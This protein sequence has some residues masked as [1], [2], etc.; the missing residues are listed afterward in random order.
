MLAC[1][2]DVASDVIGLLCA[3]GSALVFV[4]SNIFFKK[5]VP[6]NSSG[7]LASSSHKLDKL[8]LL[9]YSSGMAFLLMVPLWLYYDL[10]L[11]LV[12]YTNPDHIFHPKQGHTAPHSVTYYF[13]LNGA[14]H[15]AQNIIAFIILSSTSPV[16]YSIASLVKRVV[17]ICIAILWFNQ[18]VHPLQAIGIALTFTGLY[19]YNNAK[20][21]VEKGEKKM[22]RVQVAQDMILPTIK[23]ESREISGT[24]T[25]PNTFALSDVRLDSVL[26]ELTGPRPRKMSVLSSG[27]ALHHT[28]K[29]HYRPT[30]VSST[31]NPSSHAAPERH[32]FRPLKKESI[33]LRI[34]PVDS[35]PSPPPSLD[36][37]TS[38]SIPFSNNFLRTHELGQR[39]GPVTA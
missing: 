39:V 32:P 6:S 28:G 38:H 31:F 19:M 21:D 12:A 1:S 18:T 17:V 30:P 29:Q 34:V 5:I 37:P 16:T 35:Y 23:S 26:D 15:F 3:F 27:A 33:S 7:H 25:P 4:S 14:V 22:S 8:N 9:L 11:L 20:A 13:F 10:P 2:F 36:S 24:D